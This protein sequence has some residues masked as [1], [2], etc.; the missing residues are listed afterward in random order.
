MMRFHLDRVQMHDET[1]RLRPGSL[2]PPFSLSTLKHGSLGLP[3]EG[4]LHLQ[5][6]RFAGCPI[7]SLHL[8]SF[9]RRH[10][11]LLAQGVRV[12]AVFHSSLEA[13]SRYHEDLPFAVAAD[14]EKTLYRSFG[15]ERGVS[16]VLHP[17]AVWAAM[18]G[19]ASGPS[20]PLDSEGGLFGLPG[21]FLLGG[22]G[23][24]LASHYGGHADDHWEVDDV[25]R[26][27]ALASRP[28]T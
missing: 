19:M 11:E 3:V 26:L 23:R 8:R 22:D 20:N 10:E 16:A 18:R 13:L 1:H 21:D 14:P 12:V 17:R 25:L 2:A 4:L 27:V 9:M 7:C 15:L 24:L 28:P 5:F 6:R